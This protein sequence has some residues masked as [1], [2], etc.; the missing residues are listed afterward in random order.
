[1]RI[2]VEFRSTNKGGKKDVCTW[3]HAIILRDINNSWR[4]GV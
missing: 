3:L 4:Y 1:M 2:R